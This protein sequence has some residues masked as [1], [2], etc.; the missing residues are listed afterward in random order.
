MKNRNAYSLKKVMQL[1][2]IFQIAYNAWLLFTVIKHTKPLSGVL[3]YCSSFETLYSDVEKV[4]LVLFNKTKRKKKK[5]NKQ[6]SDCS[7][8]KYY[9][10]RFC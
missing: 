10:G 1:Y 9:G 2:N 6:L 8:L 5:I 4:K 3:N 7:H